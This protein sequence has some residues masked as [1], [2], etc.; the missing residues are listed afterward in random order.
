MMLLPL[1]T[2]CTFPQFAIIF[3]R[4]HILNQLVTLKLR[5]THTISTTVVSVI[6]LIGKGGSDWNP[7]PIPHDQITIVASILSPEM[8]DVI[9][10]KNERERMKCH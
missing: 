6:E 7:N 10:Q 3:L 1:K 4:D 9:L 5:K 2:K 8:S